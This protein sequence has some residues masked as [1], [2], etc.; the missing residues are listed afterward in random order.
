MER[1]LLAIDFNLCTVCLTSSRVRS[2]AKL[3]SRSKQ[4][5]LKVV[6]LQSSCLLIFY[7]P[8]YTQKHVKAVFLSSA[9]EC[10]AARIFFDSLDK[11]KIMMNRNH[12]HEKNET[13]EILFFVLFCFVFINVTTC[14]SC[15]SV[16]AELVWPLNNELSCYHESQRSSVQC[17][18][19]TSR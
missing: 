10:W 18:S 1:V 3:R 5:C 11:D 6:Q 8:P 7:L 13:P 2:F 14:I 17:V 16:I 19:Q 12:Q 15:S 9:K 4:D